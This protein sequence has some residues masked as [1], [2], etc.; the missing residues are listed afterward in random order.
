MTFELPK[1]DYEYNALEPH[2]DAQT[3]ELHH[4]KHHAGYT[5]KF[6]AALEK[7]PELQ[8]KSAEEIIG[9]LDIIPEDIRGAVQN[10]GGGYVNHKLFWQILKKD[11]SLSED[12][13]N[14]LEKEFGSVEDFQQGFAKAAL[15]QFGSG[16]AWLVVDSSGKLDIMSTAN[17]DSPIT[18]GFTPVLCLDVWEHAYYKKYGPARADYVKNFFHIVNWEKVEELYKKATA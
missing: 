13:K 1:L 9:D 4:S 10:N 7:H 8:K 11:V 15:N 16:W 3:M 17:Q 14:I 12:F 18:L 5:N 6:N 2:I